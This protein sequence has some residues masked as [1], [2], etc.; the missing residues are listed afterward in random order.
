MADITVSKDA[1]LSYFNA[2]SW[3]TA[4]NAAS[5]T[6]TGGGSRQTSAI[7]AYRSTSGGVKYHVLRSFF[8]FD[9][10]DISVAPTAATLKLYGYGN[11]AADVIVVKL[12]AGAT[13]SASADFVAGDFDEIDGFVTG[14]T[15][16]GNVTTYGSE[17]TTWVRNAYN[18][19]TLN[20]TAWDDMNSLDSF[21]VVVVHYDWDY[22]NIS[23]GAFN[24]SGVYYVEYTGTATDPILSYSPGTPSGY[25][26]AVS[27]VAS[28]SVSAVEAVATANISKVNGV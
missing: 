8:A 7:G 1:R 14:A 19:I 22:L 18:E 10:S 4:R 26:N 28:A 16:D 6:S 11:T 24:T 12:G 27:G 3:A 20:S 25:G 9:T 17:Y 5:A 21:G 23:P 2:A 13:G 15:M